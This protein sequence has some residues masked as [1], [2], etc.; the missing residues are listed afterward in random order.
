MQQSNAFNALKILHIALLIGMVMFAVT[1]V[2]AVQLVQQEPFAVTGE[3]FQR[4]FQVV[5]VLLSALSLIAGF[6][7]FKKKIFAARNS[8]QA[9]EKRMELYRT[10]CILWWA[11]IEGP[12]ILAGVGFILSGNYA[13]LALAIVHLLILLVFTPRKANIIMFLNL[14]SEEV[15]R[16]EGKRK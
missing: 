2:V 15:V 1:A 16:L 3:S 13:F 10:A 12:G 5:C 8:L 14:N 11:M 9:G 6:K 4:N 7:I